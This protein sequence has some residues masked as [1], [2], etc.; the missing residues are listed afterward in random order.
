[1]A[2]DLISTHPNAISRDAYGYLRVD[3]AVIN[4]EML[5]WEEWQKST[6]QIRHND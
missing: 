4:L 2:Q 6:A 1:M 3:Y 5:T